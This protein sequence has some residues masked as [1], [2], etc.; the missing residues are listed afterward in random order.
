MVL[1]FNDRQNH[2]K[3]LTALNLLFP[4]KAPFRFS[5][6]AA[7]VEVMVLG[8]KYLSPRGLGKVVT[9]RTS[10]AIDF[11]DLFPSFLLRFTS[12]PARRVV[13]DLAGD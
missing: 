13:A 2:P 11:I 6:R 10:R 3:S 1:I 8:T 7:R 4:S 12:R 9:S 5:P